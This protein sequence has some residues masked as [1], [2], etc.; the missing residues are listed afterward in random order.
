[1]NKGLKMSEP[2]AYNKNFRQQPNFFEIHLG[3]DIT[4]LID[5]MKGNPLMIEIADYSK[6]I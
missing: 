2:K 3:H 5:E 4:S 1:M 6:N